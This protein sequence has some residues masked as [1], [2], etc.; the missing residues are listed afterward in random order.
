MLLITPMRQREMSTLAESQC[1]IPSNKRVTA[2]LSKSSAVLPFRGGATDVGH[3]VL[4]K[5]PQT[6][7]LVL[8]NRV[9]CVRD[10]FS[11]RDHLP[12]TRFPFVSGFAFMLLE[13]FASA[14]LSDQCSDSPETGRIVTVIFLERQL[15]Q[16]Y[17]HA[18]LKSR[19][20]RCLFSTNFRPFTAERLHSNPGIKF[21]LK[22]VQD[23]T[24]K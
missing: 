7:E 23:L 5:I 13:W 15:P 21:R 16:I 17:C 14:P 11:R 10:V 24:A 12:Q 19:N 8:R 6:H 2:S 9:N 20:D 18:A 3:T 4:R 22:F 1:R